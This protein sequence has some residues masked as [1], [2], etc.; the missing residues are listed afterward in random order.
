MPTQ[1]ALST[2]NADS[3]EGRKAT[4]LFRA[5]YDMVSLDERQAQT[6]NENK[7][8]P[9]ALRRLIEEHS[10]PLKAPEGGYIRIVHVPVNPSREWQEAVSAAGPDTGK[11]WE[12]RIVADNYQPQKGATEEREIILVNFGK[13]VTSQ[14]VL[15]WAKLHGLF[16]EKARGMFAIGEHEPKLNFVLDMAYM[17][18]VSLEE[19]SFQGARRVPA[20]WWHETFREANLFWFLG[21]WG[22]NYWFAFSREP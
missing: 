15:D 3:P 1:G 10:M 8:L 18:V 19:C 21:S 7:G 11:D 12:I 2:L 16:P 5:A 6:L 22:D 9:A 14:H 20:L 17:A 4:E 13:S